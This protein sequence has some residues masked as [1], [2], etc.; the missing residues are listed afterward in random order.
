[1]AVRGGLGKRG[2]PGARECRSSLLWM[3]EDGGC[4]DGRPTG[5]VARWAAARTLPRCLAE[6]VL[7]L[8]A[9]SSGLGEHL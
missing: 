8:L 5:G 2:A 1:M 4:L 7:I 3:G 6:W 9:W